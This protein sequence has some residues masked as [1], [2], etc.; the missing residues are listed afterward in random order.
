[1]KINRFFPVTWLAVVALAAPVWAQTAAEQLQKGIFAQ[2]TAGDVEGAIAIYRQII[3]AGSSPREVAAQAQYRLGEALLRK[4]DLAGA[5]SEFDKLARNYPDYAPLVASIA[6]GSGGGN[7]RTGAQARMATE[8]STLD[9][10]NRRLDTATAPPP[11]PAAPPPP[12]TLRVGQNAAQINLINKTPPAYP[13]LA[14]AARV[15]GTVNFE[16]TIGK[17]GHVENLKLLS[18]PPLL[19]Q[20]AMEAVRQWV[21]KPTLLNG[22]PMNVLTTVEVNFTLS[23]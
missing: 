19:V 17:D 13:A 10:I 16:V 7:Y 8:L 14:K 20:A 5:A 2:D 6:N 23:E 1:M 21:Y 3:N 11:P 22:E 15:Q 12:G 9:R 18:G 4:G